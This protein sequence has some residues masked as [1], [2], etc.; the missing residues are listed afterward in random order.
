MFRV[1]LSIFFLFTSLASYP[2]E[3]CPIYN[4]PSEVKD[5][6][7]LGLEMRQHLLGAE[8]NKFSQMVGVCYNRDPKGLA[9]KTWCEQKRDQNIEKVFTTMGSIKK[10][11]GNVKKYLVD[12]K[13][14]NSKKDPSP[15]CQ[16]ANCGEGQFVG[17]CLAYHYG[18][19]PQDIR[20]CDSEHDHAWSLIPEKGEKN[21]YCL[22]DRWNSFRCGVKLRGKQ[23]D[24]NVWTGDVIVP[25]KSKFK[26]NKT[27]CTTLSQF[28]FP[29]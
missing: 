3:V 25:G 12:E 5:L 18:Y 28:N 4:W 29:P 10:L 13:L 6:G 17:A 22:L 7:K 21:S 24:P 20:L 26:F 9:E 15:Y 8:M 14:P 19:S 2:Q 16:Y 11:C 23:V 27:T 1:L